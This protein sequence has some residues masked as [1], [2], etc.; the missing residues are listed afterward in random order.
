MLR[1]CG[2]TPT[3]TTMLRRNVT[4]VTDWR[5]LHKIMIFIGFYSHGRG[6]VVSQMRKEPW[7][8]CA[9]GP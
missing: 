2:A 6:D 8:G 3:D 9:I 4:A 7:S 1:P 5:V